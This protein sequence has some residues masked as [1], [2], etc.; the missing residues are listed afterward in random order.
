MFVDTPCT[1]KT[2]SDCFRQVQTVSQP[3]VIEVQVKPLW[4]GFVQLRP[5][6]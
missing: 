3:G 6:E 1:V 4:R 5:P 2:S